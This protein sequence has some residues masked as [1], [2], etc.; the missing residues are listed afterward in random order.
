[1]SSEL[2]EMEEEPLIV[3]A[4]CPNCCDREDHVYKEDIGEFCCMNCNSSNKSLKIVM[5]SERKEEK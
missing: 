1:M 2:I 4:W 3:W 5:K